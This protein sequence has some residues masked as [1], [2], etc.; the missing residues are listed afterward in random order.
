M[1]MKCIAQGLDDLIITGVNF[2]K[3]DAHLRGKFAVNE[4]VHTAMLT[5]MQAR[6]KGHFFALSTCN[7]TELIG[8]HTDFDTL[9]SI[10]CTHTGND[11]ETFNSICFRK[12]GVEAIEHLFR[13]ACGLDSQILGDYE[14]VGQMRVAAAFAREHKMLGKYLDRF[15]NTAFQASKA[16]KTHTALTS[17]TVSVAFAGTKIV[18]EALGSLQDKRIVLVG[19]GKIGQH[20]L[21]NLKDYTDANHITLMNRTDAKA[22][23]LA[24][25]HEVYFAPY[26]NL[27]SQ[28]RGADVVIVATGAAMPVIHAT[29]FEG[30]TQCLLLDMSIPF[31]IDPA[32]AALPGITLRNID[33]I[34]KVNDETL[35]KRRAEVP[36]AEGIIREHIYECV[37]WYAMN[38]HTWALQHIKTYLTDMHQRELSLLKKADEQAALH[39]ET[40]S[41]NMVKVMIEK[42]ALKM[43]SN[44]DE[45]ELILK[46]FSEVLSSNPQTQA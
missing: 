15:V 44:P 21:K 28:C 42:L 23:S 43:R 8:F 11:Q 14:I 2:H 7:R 45:S 26:D 29:H 10:L 4:S 46:I 9:E 17:G 24:Q 38:R 39:L 12:Q 22:E 33:E 3:S 16:V 35:R 20:T 5:E 30:N 37:E 34:S 40:F 27:L 18:R 36:K 32:V 13:V 6:E 1:D 31:N 25:E 41:N 19:T